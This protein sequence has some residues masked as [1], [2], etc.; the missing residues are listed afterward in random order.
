MAVYD[1]Y[2]DYDA[3]TRR[4]IPVVVLTPRDEAEPT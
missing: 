3:W 1:G 2:D 4:Q